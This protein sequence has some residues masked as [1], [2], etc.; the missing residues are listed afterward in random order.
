MIFYLDDTNIKK[1][2]PYCTL[3]RS[4]WNDWGYYATFF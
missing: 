1:E 3:E 2:Y 4:D